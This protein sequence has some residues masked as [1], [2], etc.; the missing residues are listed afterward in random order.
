[1]TAIYVLRGPSGSGKTSTLKRVREV[2]LRN[3]TGVITDNDLSPRLKADIHR[4]LDPVDGYRVGVS[5]HGDHE[6]TIKKRVNKLLDED[7]CI[8]FTA[9]S[10]PRIAADYFEDLKKQGHSVT[11]V[12]FHIPGSTNDQENNE[13]ARFLIRIAGL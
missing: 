2:L 1:M 3:Y 12:W 4:I 13:R 6:A 11:E 10:G 5:S 7:P 9:A 8:I